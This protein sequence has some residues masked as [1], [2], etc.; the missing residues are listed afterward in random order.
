MNGNTNFYFLIEDVKDFKRRAFIKC[1]F[2]KNC[3]K[4]FLKY[5]GSYNTYKTKEEYNGIIFSIHIQFVKNVEIQIYIE[6]IGEIINCALIMVNL[7]DKTALLQF[8]DENNKLIISKLSINSK[9]INIMNFIK[10]IIIKKILKKLEIQY[11][12]IVNVDDIDDSY[13]LKI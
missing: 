4:E 1:W 9:Y 5:D 11:I 10:N 6:T 8:L 7:I 3:T 2:I 13:R 12:D